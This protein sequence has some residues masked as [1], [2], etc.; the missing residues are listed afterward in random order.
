MRM[1]L[2]GAAVFTFSI[3]LCSSATAESVP[4]IL[5]NFPVT[6]D[7]TIKRAYSERIRASFP[8][9]IRTS[10]L[11]ALLEM[12]GFTVLSTSAGHTARFVDAVFPCITDYALSW[13]ENDRG[14][15]KNMKVAMSHKCV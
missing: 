10:T 8:R 2:K 3:F 4:R 9:D 14:H 7:E 12:D 5:V 1:D 11:R 13:D 6:Q 15:V